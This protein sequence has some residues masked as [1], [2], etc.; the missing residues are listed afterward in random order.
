MQRPPR[1]LLCA[2]GTLQIK[3]GIW[4]DRCPW[5]QRLQLQSKRK[6]SER[7]NLLH[8]KGRCYKETTTL[9]SLWLQVR[10]AQALARSSA[11]LPEH[12]KTWPED[13]RAKAKQCSYLNSW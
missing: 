6:R 13:T 10:G 9:S 12:F 7:R 5:L 1:T 11:L 4:E 2:L 8:D 3:A